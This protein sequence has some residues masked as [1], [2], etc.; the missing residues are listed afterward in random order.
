MEGNR[1]WRESAWL[2]KAMG[3][4]TKRQDLARKLCSFSS[5]YRTPASYL[6]VLAL[7][8][9]EIRQGYF[10]QPGRSCIHIRGLLACSPRAKENCNPSVKKSEASPTPN[11]LSVA[12]PLGRV[13]DCESVLAARTPPWLY[14]WGCLFS[15]TMMPMQTVEPFTELQAQREKRLPMFEVLHSIPA[16]HQVKFIYNTWAI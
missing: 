3:C 12:S 11:P 16:Y 9:N 4:R 1:A 6:L 15:V 10:N 7:T 13:F 8:M 5:S 2:L 14:V